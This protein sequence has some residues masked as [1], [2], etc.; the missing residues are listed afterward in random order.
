MKNLIKKNA[1]SEA[2]LELIEN[3]VAKI[4]KK[5]ANNLRGGKNAPVAE[6]GGDDSINTEFTEHRNCC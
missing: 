6:T 3:F 1:K 2:K 4:E 5:E